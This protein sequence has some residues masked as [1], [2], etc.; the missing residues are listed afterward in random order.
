MLQM[1]DR[2]DPVQTPLEPEQVPER[3]GPGRL[4]LLQQPVVRFG[5]VGA[6]ST[7]GY[8]M[9]YAALRL[10]LPPLFAN[11]L[12]LLATGDVNTWLN[13][14][15]SF[16]EQGPVPPTQRV[17]GVAAYL[18]SLVSSSGALELLVLLHAHGRTA[19]L[20]ALAVANALA[21]VVHYLLLRRWAFR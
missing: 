2:P 7:A 4:G 17:K 19:E 21:G 6:A 1:L 10:C 20:T 16:G 13:R 8:L 18:V 15:W 9:L 11:G 12:A 3:R 14:R 5:L